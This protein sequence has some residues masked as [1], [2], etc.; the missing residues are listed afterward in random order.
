M[1]PGQR[2]RIRARFLVTAP[3]PRGYERASSVLLTANARLM[4]SS[5]D[6]LGEMQCEL[7]S[8]MPAL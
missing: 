3:P 4:I 7:F 1:R 5:G 2:Q 8:S 6:D